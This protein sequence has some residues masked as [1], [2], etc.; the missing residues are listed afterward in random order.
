MDAIDLNLK[1][2]EKNERRQKYEKLIDEVLEVSLNP[3]DKYEVAAIIE[4]RGWNDR[5]VLKTFGME[6]IFELSENLWL[7]IQQRVAAS[8]FT[9]PKKRSLTSNANEIIRSFLRGTIFALPMVI[10]IASML[11]LKFSLWSYLYLSTDLATAIA[12]GTILSFMAVGGYTQAI[13]RRG[14]FYIRQGFFNMC[15]RT[16]YFFLKMGFVSFIVLSVLF[17]LFNLFYLQLPYNM[18][19]ISIVYFL[20][21]S[22][23]WISV[24]IMYILQKELT[25]TGLIAAGIGV[26]YVMFRIFN[27]SII[28]SQIIGLSFISVSGFA[29]VMY[30]FRISERKMEKGIAP[31]LPKRSIMLYSIMPSFNY[32]FLY[33]TFLFCDR[34]IAWS[35]NSL[36]MP[37][38]IW[39]RGEYELG[40]DFALLM[41]VVPMGFCEVIINKFMSRIEETQ[42]NDSYGEYGTLSSNYIKLYTKSTLLLVIVAAVS[43]VLIYITV[44]S[45][46]SGYISLFN[47]KFSISETTHFVLIIALTA[48]GILAIGLSN[49]MVLFSLSQPKMVTK[50]ILIALLVNVFSGF[51]LSRW[52]GYSYAVFGLLLGS[53]VFLFL[54]SRSVLR[55]LSNLDYYMYAAT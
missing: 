3:M 53:I 31:T 45:I 49:S 32:G 46:S 21:L 51:V 26:V 29:L 34:V 5:R 18:M 37:Y 28:I 6:S 9:S 50:P 44:M 19:L 30:F 11:T 16:T 52:F 24:T 40:L 25:F 39:F 42:R 43:G 10:S 8:P 15:K 38:F 47:I 48:Y 4:S 23:N 36:Y 54:S 2:N 22:I 33:F 27:Q 12:I 35:T 13:A 7:S 20:F 17:V 1:R 14:F 41:L 55:V